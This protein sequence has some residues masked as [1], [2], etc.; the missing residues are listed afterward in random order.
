MKRTFF[1]SFALVCFL[2]A[3]W[4]KPDAPALELSR[5]PSAQPTAHE[6]KRAPRKADRG[7]P[8]FVPPA[9]LGS[10][11]AAANAY[12]TLHRDA[13]GIQSHHQLKPEEYRSPLG[14][15]VKYSVYQGKHLV[16]GLQLEIFVNK[17]G[18]VSR[19]SNG[20]RPVEEAG[21]EAWEAPAKNFTD[22]VTVFETESA[23]VALLFVPENSPAS[24]AEP[25]YAVQVKNKTTQE[26]HQGIFRA[27]DGQMLALSKGRGEP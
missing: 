5:E 11:V 7:S 2:G 25:A 9:D 21:E 26:T 10:P 19:V 14:S 13:L 27:S 17:K 23:P 15:A 4:L 24:K 8:S 3:L 20:Y 6:P 16:M 18:S 22:G 12:V 1:V